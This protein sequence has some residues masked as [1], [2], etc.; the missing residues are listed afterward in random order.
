MKI[1]STQNKIMYSLLT[2]TGM[3][4]NKYNLI[5]GFTKGRTDKSN[6]MSMDEAQELITYLKVFIT[7]KDKLQLHQDEAANQMRRKIIS[8]SHRIGWT[9]QPGKVDMDSINT[10]C[11]E[12]SYL[13]KELNNYTYNELPKL[14]TEF[15]QV[16]KYYISKAF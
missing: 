8:M 1:T 4:G 3:L 11:R 13:K 9:T 2:K 6:E 16:Y 14:V 5:L 7:N 15:Q 12:K 10:W